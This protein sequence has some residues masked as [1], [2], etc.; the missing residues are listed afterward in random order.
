MTPAAL[1]PTGASRPLAA[2]LAASGVALLFVPLASTFSELVTQLAIALQLDGAL[3]RWIAPAEGWLARG[4]LSLVGLPSATEG[5]IL[6]VGAGA[7]AVPLYIA[8]NCVG[9]QTLLLFGISLLTGLQG[10]WSARSRIET[11]A[12][13]LFGIALLNVLRIAVIGIVAY[14]F[15]PIPAILVHDYGT[16]FVSVGFLVAFWVFAYELVLRPATSPALPGPVMVVEQ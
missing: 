7:Q 14:T 8:W 15:G 12:L 3:G 1:A 16:I 10:S 11:I 6:Y 5:S 9:W 2:V 13:G 4:V